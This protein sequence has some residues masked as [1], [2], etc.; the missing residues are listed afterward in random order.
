MVGHKL[1]NLNGG[2]TLS[3]NQESSSDGVYWRAYFPP[4]YIKGILLPALALSTGTGCI[5][6]KSIIYI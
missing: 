2:P 4:H 3:S 5:S 6:V 1:D